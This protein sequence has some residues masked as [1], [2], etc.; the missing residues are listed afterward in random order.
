[1]KN[2]KVFR[3]RKA[4]EK[5]WKRDAFIHHSSG[6]GGTKMMRVEAAAC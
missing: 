4:E 3:S 2:E 1:M 6:G 5:R